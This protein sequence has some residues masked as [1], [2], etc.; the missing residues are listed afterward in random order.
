[1]NAHPML[2]FMDE[3]IARIRDSFVIDESGNVSQ[4]DFVIDERGNMTPA[5]G[6]ED[7]IH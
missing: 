2:G 3:A 7:A 4:G 5:R 1:M 6:D